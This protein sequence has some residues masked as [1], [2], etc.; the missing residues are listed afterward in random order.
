MNDSESS[1]LNEQ[2]DM[3]DRAVFDE[4]SKFAEFSRATAIFYRK[5]DNGFVL[6][7]LKISSKSEYFQNWSKFSIFSEFYT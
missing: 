2:I 7:G 6:R 4:K 5:T 1:G 3:A